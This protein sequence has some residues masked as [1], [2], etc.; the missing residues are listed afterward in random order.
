MAT[1]EKIEYRKKE[2]KDVVKDSVLWLV[3]L[4]ISFYFIKNVVQGW[5][6]SPIDFW[7]ALLAS[8][9]ATI[10]SIHL[11]KLSFEAFRA[12][13]KEVKNEFY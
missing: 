8:L 10:S 5:S 12:T 6:W 13:T 3:V 11:G 7:Y 2:N 9:Y 1:K 4:G